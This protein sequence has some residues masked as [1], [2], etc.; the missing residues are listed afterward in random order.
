MATSLGE[1]NKTYSGNHGLSDDPLV[2]A[3]EEFTIS[4]LALA[5]NITEN[6]K[7][8]C[9]AT[10]LTNPTKSIPAK[11]TQRDEAYLYDKSAK[12]LNS[13]A[14]LWQVDCH[15]KKHIDVTT[16]SLED[17]PKRYGVYTWGGESLE[18]ILTEDA[19]SGRPTVNSV[20]EEFDIHHPISIPVLT[21]S[22][23]LPP[24]PPHYILTYLNKVNSVTFLAGQ[25]SSSFPGFPPGTALMADIQDVPIEIS[26][27]TQRKVTY[28]IKFNLRSYKN[29]QGVPKLLGWRERLMNIGTKYYKDPYNSSHLSRKFVV[30]NKDVTTGWLEYDG[31]KRE[32]DQDV[33]PLYIIINRFE[34]VNFNNLG[35]E[36]Q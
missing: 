25:L 19:L 20:G 1:I 23:I 33:K 14:L 6:L 36:L 4:Y 31:T 24:L 10:S 26:G 21:F 18:E 34:E 15:Y 8:I 35:I 11:R 17:G 30:D 22:K 9:S 3:E 13:A 27:V 28:V 29:E 5:D 16:I 32:Q 2:E 7:S 12:E